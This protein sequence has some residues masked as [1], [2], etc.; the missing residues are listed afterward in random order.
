[1]EQLNLLGAVGIGNARWTTDDL[2]ERYADQRGDCRYPAFQANTAYGYGCRC[3][4]CV[5][6]R[7]DYYKHIRE[8]GAPKC[9][10]ESCTNPKAQGI[11]SKW[12][13]EHAHSKKLCKYDGCQ[14]LKARGSGKRYCFEH[15]T[16]INGELLCLVLCLV[17]GRQAR[18]VRDH[19]YREIC[20]PCRQETQKLIKNA[21][22]H[23][24]PINVLVEWI[25]HPACKLCDQRFYLG[26]GGSNHD[27]VI[28][29]DHACCNGS[30]SCGQCVRGILC[31]RCNMS[32]G[33]LERMVTRSGLGN[34][35]TYLNATYAKR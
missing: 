4:G 24:V 18:S 5:M 16:M 33:H 32:L 34:I 19:P 26:G 25:K 27:F 31:G 20:T 6:H 1:M 14:N 13:S 3:R 35:M 23:H 10:V 21:R 22:S 28:D 29:H 30:R 12:C 11:G 15:S 9:P 7:A 17:C 8:L 2:D